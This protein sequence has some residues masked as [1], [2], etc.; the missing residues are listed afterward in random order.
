M[1]ISLIECPNPANKNKGKKKI[2]ESSTQ[3]TEQKG[4]TLFGGY[5]I[6]GIPSIPINSQNEEED[7]DEDLFESSNPKEIN[8]G[9]KQN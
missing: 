8:K 5:H 7:D 9:K 6:P 2:G 4:I 1:L 3:S